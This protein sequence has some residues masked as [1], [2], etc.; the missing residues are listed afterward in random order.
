PTPTQLHGARKRRAPTKYED[1]LISSHSAL[2]KKNRTPRQEIEET[3]THDFTPSPS[4]EL[5][6]EQEFT[7]SYRSPSEQLKPILSRHKTTPNDAGIFRVYRYSKPSREPDAFVT[8]TDVTNSS[9]FEHPKRSN[10]PTAQDGFGPRS[11]ALQAPDV[12]GPFDNFASFSL[13]DWAYRFKTTSK[14]AL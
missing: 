7:S 6:L 13:I 11:K 5:Q 4:P 3:P 14:E 10:A 12:Y 2:V 9:T 8:T 1:F